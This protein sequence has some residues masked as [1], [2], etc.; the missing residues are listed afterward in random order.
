MRHFGINLNSIDLISQPDLADHIL[1]AVRDNV[2]NFVQLHARYTPEYYDG[3]L[4]KIE[5]K[6]TGIKAIVHAPFYIPSK[7]NGVNTSDESWLTQN[8]QALEF[9]QKCADLL[10]SEIIIL[11]PGIGDS[12]K[13]VDETIRQ[14][15]LINDSRITIE[16]LPYE[17]FGCFMHGGRFE[18]ISRI[19][20]EADC[21]FCFDFAH[22]VCAAISLNI[23]IYDS[24]GKYKALN[25][26]LY[27]LSDG[28][29]SIS[30]DAHLHLGV[31]NYDIKRFLSE[32]SNTDAMIVL[33]TF[34]P[35]SAEIEPWLKDAD[36]LKKLCI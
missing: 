10:Q 12:D 8:I 13:C 3:I 27:H 18:N 6:M 7:Y 26:I 11:H 25:P 24:L 28:D 21:K 30:F 33:E 36:Y 23:D 19:V 14:V 1:K 17:V 16:N 15:R 35:P 4:R 20:N 32:F 5:Q 2:Y 22:A 9:S 34:N 31:G 29:I